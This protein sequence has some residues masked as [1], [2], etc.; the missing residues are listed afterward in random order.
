MRTGDA[1]AAAGDFGIPA[2]SSVFG[3]DVDSET[4]ASAS[5]VGLHSGSLH[6]SGNRPAATPLVTEPIA[7]DTR[8]TQMGEPTLVEASPQEMEVWTDYSTSPQWADEQ[9]HLPPVKPH[10][11]VGSADDGADFFGYDSHQPFSGY[12]ALTKSPARD[13][14]MAV[15]VGA[16]LAAIACLAMWAGPQAMLAL[17][18]VVLGLTAV[19]L[20]NAL[21]M[22]DF[23]PAV[24]LGLASVIGMPL[25]VY[26]RGMAAMVV[27]LVL[28][29][30]FGTLWYLTGVGTE[31]PLRG[32]ACTLF[33]VAYIGVLGSH[34]ALLLT[35]PEHGMG[36]ITAA[37]VFTAAYDVGGLVV[38]R[39]AGRNPLSKA[40]PS[41]TLEGLVGGC[42]ITLAVGI[43]MGLIALP[44]PVADNPGNLWTAIA[45]AAA[46]AVAAPVG[47]L[48]ESLLKRD[49]DLKD[50]GT[51]L[52]G[53]GGALDRFDSLLFVIPVTYYTALMTGVIT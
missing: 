14:R 19:E 1:D 4:K 23:Q 2:G 12:Q 48:A 37:I 33:T 9:S 16:L 51:L 26:W 44:A 25:A 20:L 3:D 39:A 21:R 52:P 24:L 34:A 6:S 45:L 49:L 30:L 7:A 47:D 31:G 36:L 15:I 27:V 40:S 17:I 41:K 18:V 53:H 29:V 42:I 10:E 22:A 43:C 13:M 32:L 50:M 38:G 46:A 28:T 8:T 35:I 11:T 5:E